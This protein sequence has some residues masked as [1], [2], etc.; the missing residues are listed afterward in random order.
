MAV[1]PL[2]VADELRQLAH[3]LRASL[4]HRFVHRDRG[5]RSLRLGLLDDEL[6][7]YVVPVTTDIV[8]Y[9]FLHSLSFLDELLFTS[10]TDGAAV[11]VVITVRFTV[12][13]FCGSS[14]LRFVGLG[15]RDL[16]LT[17]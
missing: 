8:L 14:V 13:A 6:V 11:I 2:D 10:S 12:G 15:D 9:G 4:L 7:H 5:L 3:I 17:V 16:A 1:L